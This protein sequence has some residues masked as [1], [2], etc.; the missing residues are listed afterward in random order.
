MLNEN[1]VR[2]RRRQVIETIAMLDEQ[3]AVLEK[4]LA[5]DEAWLRLHG[6]PVVDT[7][8]PGLEQRGSLSI[9]ASAEIVEN[10]PTKTQL[11]LDILREARGAAVPVSVIWE[12]AVRRGATSQSKDPVHATDSTL[13][14]LVK[15]NPHVVLA[16]PRKF[17][18]REQ[19]Q[20]QPDAPR[21]FMQI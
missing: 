20:P 5:S 21:T 17:A 1:D 13:R 3:R 16:G 11:Y 15:S 6:S 18:W 12:E 2:E 10:E 14:L 4:M 19:E 8:L 7:P 9:G